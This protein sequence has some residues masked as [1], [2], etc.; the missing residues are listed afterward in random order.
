MFVEVRDPLFTQRAPELCSLSPKAGSQDAHGMTV[1]P[2]RSFHRKTAG[3]RE[4]EAPNKC[5]K[6]LLTYS[7]FRKAR[8][9]E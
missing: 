5:F 7:K 8:N 1:Y 4:M 9:A 6:F 3:R 2:S